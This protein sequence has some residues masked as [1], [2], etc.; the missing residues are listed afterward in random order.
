[1]TE[2]QTWLIALSIEQLGQ[3]C[4]AAGVKVDGFR[5]LNL[6]PRLLLERQIMMVLNRHRGQ[7]RSAKLR[8][9]LGSAWRERYPALEGLLKGGLTP[10]AG[11]E[12][13]ELER[14][15]EWLAGLCRTF[16][17]A[18]VQMGVQVMDLPWAEN[19]RLSQL[20][21]YWPADVALMPTPAAPE[22]VE[23]TTEVEEDE[24]A[25]VALRPEWRQERSQLRAKLKSL[26]QENQGLQRARTSAEYRAAHYQAQVEQVRV[27]M[28]ALAN[29]TDWPHP[30]MMVQRLIHGLMEARRQILDLEM[31]NAE[32]RLA[33]GQTPEA[34]AAADME[35]SEE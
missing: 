18:P 11:D 16:G 32:L 9:A 6:V 8:A 19:E 29:R 17:R 4:K 10:A 33:L 14:W 3:A 21:P 2:E 31:A 15:G 5:H 22:G 23:P 30:R 1:M 12:R 20:E 27:E 28:E 24:E 34:E 7:A 35:E 13:P 25:T 26:A